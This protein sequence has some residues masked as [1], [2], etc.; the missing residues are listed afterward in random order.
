MSRRACPRR[1]EGER[2]G[3]GCAEHFG[4][5]R[6]R[7]IGWNDE[8]ERH[9]GGERNRLQVRVRIV[10]QSLDPMLVDCHFGRLAQQ[11]RVAVRSSGH[12]AVGANCS[13]CAGPVLHDHV[14]SK[15]ERELIGKQP[16]DDIA[17]AARCVGDHEVQSMGWKALRPRRRHSG[18]TCAEKKRYQRDRFHAFSPDGHS[19]RAAA[20]RSTQAEA[21]RWRASHSLSKRATSKLC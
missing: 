16:R 17:G 19:I 3:F 10:G 14:L 18:K 13:A 8:R 7:R 1:C 20:R 9:N 15:S 11:Q 2:M 6:I 12:H 21:Y 5:G 4:H